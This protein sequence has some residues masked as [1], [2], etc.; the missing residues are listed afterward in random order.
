VAIENLCKRYLNHI[1]LPILSSELS[2]N[3]M[4][5]PNLALATQD[6]D[7]MRDSYGRYAMQQCS[8]MPRRSDLDVSLAHLI[9][10]ANI[11]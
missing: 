1:F 10:T 6:R 2:G 8:E 7:R 11:L 4:V 9:S 5:G 3:R